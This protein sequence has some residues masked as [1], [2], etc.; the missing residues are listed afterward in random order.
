[1]SYRLLL[2][3]LTAIQQMD[4]RYVRFGPAKR[5]D[6]KN[7]LKLV[8][9]INAPIGFFEQQISEMKRLTTFLK[10]VVQSVQE[11]ETPPETGAGVSPQMFTSDNPGMVEMGLDYSGDEYDQQNEDYSDEGSSLKGQD[12]RSYYHPNMEPC[13]TMMKPC[14]GQT[15]GYSELNMLPSRINLD[16]PD[17]P[18]S[19]IGP[20][21]YSNMGVMALRRPDYGGDYAGL[22]VPQPEVVDPLE[23]IEYTDVKKTADGN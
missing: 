17:Y 16:Y 6:M 4:M 23:N 14:L 19:K 5:Q 21:D 22:P 3:V 13:G 11:S 10:M 12:Y 18:E 2:L 7:I 9:A 15:Q 20:N 8:D 1:M